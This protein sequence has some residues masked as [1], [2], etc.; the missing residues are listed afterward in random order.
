MKYMKQLWSSGINKNYFPFVSFT[1]A[2]YPSLNSSILKLVFCMPTTSCV[3]RSRIESWLKIKISTKSVV[4]KM[5]SGCKESHFA[6]FH[7]SKLKLAF[8]LLVQTSFQLAPKTC[9]RVELI[10]Q[11]YCN[12]NSLK[13]FT[14]VSVK[15]RKEFTSLIAKST[16]PWISDTTFFA[17]YVMQNWYKPLPLG[18]HRL[19]YSQLPLR[20]TPWRPIPCVRPSYI[21]S[22]L[23][24]VKKGSNQL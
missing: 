14:C 21:E 24:G 10:S 11:F 1:Q 15:L 4:G 19:V 9:L 17:R 12:W 8:D 6:V 3:I 16:S 7:L 2:L 13:N 18:P 22:Q 5:L 20:W 23:K